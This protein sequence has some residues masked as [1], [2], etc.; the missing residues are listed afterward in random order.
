MEKAFLEWKKAEQVR[1]IT[2]VLGGKAGDLA[3]VSDEVY[4]VDSLGLEQ[5]CIQKGLSI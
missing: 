3:K 4:E 1:A 2:I 5:E